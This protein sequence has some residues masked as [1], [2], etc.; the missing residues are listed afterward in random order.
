MGT[1][2]WRHP[3]LSFIAVLPGDQGVV[4]ASRDGSIRLWD[5]AT[6]KELR[7]FQKPAEDPDLTAKLPKPD[8]GIDGLQMERMMRLMGGDGSTR[9]LT[10]PAVSADGKV[11]AQAQG[12]GRVF[13]WDAATAKSLR[14][15]TLPE[16]AGV[17]P[18][19]TRVLR[20]RSE[21]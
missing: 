11:L 2:R 21:K 3:G 14:T 20:R 8:G 15:I 7:R 6:G 9:G 1:I 12:D 5:G 17:T 18:N 10:E 13:L 19:G 16:A 4:T